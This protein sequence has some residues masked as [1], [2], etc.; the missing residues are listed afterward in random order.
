MKSMGGE[1]GR[2]LHQKGMW[3]R[4]AEGTSKRGCEGVIPTKEKRR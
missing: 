3:V 1:R 2:D 4:Y